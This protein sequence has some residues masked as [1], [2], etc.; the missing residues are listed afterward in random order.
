MKQLINPLLAILVMMMAYTAIQGQPGRRPGPPRRRH[1]VN[2]APA[3]LSLVPATE[4]PPAASMVS[5]TIDGD[6]R[7]IRANGIP[8]HDTG[9]FPNQGNPHQ[10]SEQSYSYRIPAEPQFAPRITPLG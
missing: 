10:I 3:K 1:T 7:V 4:K 6:E 8:E 2:Q 5:V 9:V